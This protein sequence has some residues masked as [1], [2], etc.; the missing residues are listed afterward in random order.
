MFNKIYFAVII[1][2]FL[3]AMHSVVQAAR[4]INPVANILWFC[5]FAIMTALL[6]VARD[7]GK[8]KPSTNLPRYYFRNKA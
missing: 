7:W 4:N 2:N 6:Y 5:A 8:Y 1:L 3:N